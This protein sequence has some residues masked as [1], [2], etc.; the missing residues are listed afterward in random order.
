[1][2]RRFAPRNFDDISAPNNTETA[3]RAN[4][5]TWQST[6]RIGGL[7]PD[8]RGLNIRS[9]IT[10]IAS[11][12]TGFAISILFSAESLGLPRRTGVLLA[13]SIEVKSKLRATKW[14]GGSLA[15][16]AMR[17]KSK[18]RATKWR[19][20]SLAASVMRIKS[21]LRVERSS[22][23]TASAGWELTVGAEYSQLAH[24]GL[25][26]P[27]GLRN[28]DEYSIAKQIRNCEEGEQPDAAVHW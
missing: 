3:R 17:I 9:R 14:R 4:S 18:L 15:A 24:C 8:C 26:Q 23:L 5:P 2:P 1:M 21:K 25:L 19:G 10:W 28:F 13:I 7:S 20:G 22:P 16:S 11:A 6:G 12:L 27:Y